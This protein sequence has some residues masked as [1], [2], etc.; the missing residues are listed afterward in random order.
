MRAS[1]E[2]KAL[3]PF[4]ALFFLDVICARLML[5]FVVLMNALWSLLALSTV[6]LKP[7]R[8][9]SALLMTGINHAV[10]A[11]IMIFRTGINLQ[12]MFGL[13]SEKGKG[14]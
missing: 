4:G 9:T 1:K 8:A 6:V 14:T 13:K 2:R 5:I 12:D 10:F 11:S 3:P 7:H